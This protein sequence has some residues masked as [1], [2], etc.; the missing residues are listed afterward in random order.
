MKGF[1][2]DTSRKIRIGKEIENQ[3][4]KEK[5]L[6]MAYR[7]VMSKYKISEQTAKEC[8]ECFIA[9]KIGKKEGEEK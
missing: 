1:K 2:I 3:I 6:F 7:P 5:Y 8:Y 4:P 9:Y